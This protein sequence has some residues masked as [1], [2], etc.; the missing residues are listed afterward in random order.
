MASAQSIKDIWEYIISIGSWEDGIKWS[1][2]D[3][4]LLCDYTQYDWIKISHKLHRL[5]CEQA[6]CTK[7][8]FYVNAHMQLN[9]T[10]IFYILS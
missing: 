7:A 3:L 5:E 10:R 4:L 2:S 8:L 1:E 9:Y 6:Y